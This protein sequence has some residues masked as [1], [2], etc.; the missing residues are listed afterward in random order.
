[1]VIL[2]VILPLYAAWVIA[3][4]LMHRR[5]ISKQIGRNA[6]VIQPFADRELPHRYLELVLLIGAVAAIGDIALNAVATDW[7]SETIG[8]PILRISDT[9]RLIGFVVMTA[10]LLLSSVA[11]RQMGSSWRIGIDAE[12]AGALATRGL[13]ARMR[14]PIYTGM[15]LATTGLAA[16]TGDAIAVSVA[17]G[18]GVALPIQARLE[19]QFLLSRHGDEYRAYLERTGRFLPKSRARS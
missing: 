17:V 10:G 8:I 14:H 2:H 9:P 3:A 15:L 7:V 6:V 19:E 16:T 18:C 11:V 13:Y 5:R 12:G 4:L 1:V